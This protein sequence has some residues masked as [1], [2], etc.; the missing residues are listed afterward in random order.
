MELGN[1][2]YICISYKDTSKYLNLTL[3]M[4]VKIKSHVIIGFAILTNIGKPQIHVDITNSFKDSTFE[5]VVKKNDSEF[6]TQ[7]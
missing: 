3:K 7:W 4:W 6:Y 2:D 1:N 5:T